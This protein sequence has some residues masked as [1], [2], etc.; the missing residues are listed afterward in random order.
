MKQSCVPLNYGYVSDDPVVIER[1]GI[2]EQNSIRAIDEEAGN[3]KG[4][5]QN[6]G[7]PVGVEVA[8]PSEMVQPCWNIYHELAVDEDL[9]LPHTVVKVVH[10]ETV[11]GQQYCT[12][13]WG[14]D[15]QREA[16]GAEGVT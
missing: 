3:V 7:I 12:A 6:I 2:F 13:P 14:S 16:A 8:S 4:S 9:E 1:R 5:E 15:V 10:V 11:E